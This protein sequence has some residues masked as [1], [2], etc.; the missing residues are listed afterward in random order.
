MKKFLTLIIILAF[1]GLV[2]WQ[3]YQKVSATGNRTG[4][5]RRVV[6]VAVEVTP[7]KKTTINDVGFFTGTLH[8]KSQFIV[9]PKVGGRLERLFVN[10]GDRVKRGQSIA[11]LEDDEYLQ[12]VDQARAELEVAKAKIEETRSN[13]GI[14]DR[15]FDRAKALRKK[16]IASQSELETAE[17]QFN[18]QSAMLRVAKAQ[19]AQKEAALKASQVRLSYTRIQ[20]SWENGDEYR[21]VGERFVHEGA[22]LAPNASIVSI[23]D[24]GSLTAVVHVIERDYSKILTGQEAVVT[25]DAYPGRR[26]SGMVV[27]IAPL[28]RETSRQARIEIEVPNPDQ[29]LRPGMYIRIQVEFEKHPDAIVVPMPAL[30]KRQGRDGV[31]LVDPENKM[32][33]FIPVTV[34]ITNDEWVEVVEPPL[35]GLVVTL[36]QHLLSDGSPIILPDAGP[37]KSPPG[38]RGNDSPGKDGGRS[39]PGGRP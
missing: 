33:R 23:L 9:A 39:G 13:L 35:S 19:M 20:A 8:P 37:G 22:M 30:I 17:A 15:E 12:Q 21:V 3:V 2:G 24:I 28:L 34:G 10:I 5:Q 36:G 1:L 32:A 25:T 38:E 29:S 31:F 11:L 26:F 7:V 27:R 16:K 4:R 18:A 6:P 14:A